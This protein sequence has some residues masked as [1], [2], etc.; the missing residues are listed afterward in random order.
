MILSESDIY[1][2]VCECVSLLLEGNMGTLYHFVGIDSL[3][4][5]LKNNRFDLNDCG[6]GTYYMSA[7]RNRNSRQ[8]YPYMQSD[9]SLGGGTYH[10]PGDEGIIIRLELDG[11]KLRAYG[12]IK[13]FDYL[14]DEGDVIDDDGNRL[15]GKQEAMTYVGDFEE[16]YHQ[17]FSQGEERLASKKKSIKNAFSIIKRIDIYIDPFKASDKSWQDTYGKRVAET[18]VTWRKYLHIYDD[19]TKFDHQ[20]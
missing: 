19:R 2:M 12:K 18:I 16:M 17:P 7:T 14:Y 9:Y 15:N 10:N 5:I 8:G 20:A 11:E 4:H 6:D 1:K 13:P 3:I